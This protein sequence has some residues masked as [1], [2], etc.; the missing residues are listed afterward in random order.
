MQKLQKKN[1]ML[2]FKELLIVKSK[3]WEKK[4]IKSKI[5]YQVCK[6]KIK[7]KKRFFQLLKNPFFRKKLTTYRRIRNCLKKK[8]FFFRHF[9]Y[10][11]E[12]YKNVSNK[13]YVHLFFY[14]G[15]S[16]NNIFCLLKNKQKNIK[17]V[18][19]GKI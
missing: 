8:G 13:E 11:N 1:N 2:K 6:K 7:K 4:K 14:L 19:C 9:F 5:F 16:S 17:D 12:F 15:I 3:R 18:F 10:K